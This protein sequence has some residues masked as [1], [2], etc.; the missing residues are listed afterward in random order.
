[1]AS[2][3]TAILAGST[4]LSP[5]HPEPRDGHCTAEKG[6]PSSRH[7]TN[8]KRHHQSIIGLL[9]MSPI[10]V[11]CPY[12]DVFFLRE[13]PSQACPRCGFVKSPIFSSLVTSSEFTETKST[14]N[15]Q[16]VISKSR[17][18]DTNKEYKKCPY[19]DA[20]FSAQL[21]AI[22][23]KNHIS[24]S[25]PRKAKAKNPRPKKVTPVIDPP[26]VLLG[27]GY[28]LKPRQQRHI[29]RIEEKPI[30]DEP[31]EEIC[32][33]CN[34][35]GGIR[36]GCDLCTGSGWVSSA[37]RDKYQG[38]AAGI[39]KNTPSKVSNADYLGANPGAHFRD[40][41]GRIGSNPTHDNYGEEGSA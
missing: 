3:S 22:L 13:S 28:G 26:L 37:T 14:G 17:R 7:S 9:R 1:M 10:N 15:Q 30:R 29:P 6:L 12:C 23:I 41:N 21:Y 8:A 35:D 38:L 18:S 27:R 34:G 4:L 40:F 31:K 16:P 33:R 2:I 36:Q 11:K 20:T 5:P 19:C 32:P 39:A 24:K 25:H